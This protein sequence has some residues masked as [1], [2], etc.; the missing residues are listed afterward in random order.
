[1]LG[2]RTP[3]PNVSVASASSTNRAATIFIRLTDLFP[4]TSRWLLDARCCTPHNYGLERG[5]NDRLPCIWR[6]TAAAQPTRSANLIFIGFAC[7]PTR[8]PTSR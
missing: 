7:V 6:S 8:H 4:P 2:C 3:A 1:M 5:V